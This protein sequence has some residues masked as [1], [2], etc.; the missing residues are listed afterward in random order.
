MLKILYFS[1]TLSFDNSKI[2]Y[3]KGKRAVFTLSKKIQII[4]KLIAQLH[5]RVLNIDPIILGFK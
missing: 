4:W 1:E 2:A 5:Q 3:S